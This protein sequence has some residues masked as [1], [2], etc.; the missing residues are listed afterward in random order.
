VSRLI[1]FFAQFQQ[2]TI[3]RFCFVLAFCKIFDVAF[4]TR[5]EI[6]KAGA[7][8]FSFGLLIFLGY[9]VLLCL[10]VFLMNWSLPQQAGWLL[11]SM[12]FVSYGVMIGMY[13]AP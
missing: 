13:F 6:F 12:T 8:E 1:N 10:L 3:Y 5:Y 11:I 9:E 7:K 2:L 4:K